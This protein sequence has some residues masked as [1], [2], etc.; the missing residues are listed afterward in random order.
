MSFHVVKGGVLTTI[1]DL[2]RTGF[3]DQGVLESGAMDR[4]S[5]RTA[6]LLVGNEESEACLE[7]TLN[8]PEI[9]INKDSLIAVTGEGMVPFIEGER[10]P[11]GTPIYV[12]AG[13]TLHF[14]STKTGCRTYLAVAGGLEV[15]VVMNSKST[16]L[17]A[18]LGGYK[19]RALQKGDCL[20]IGEESDLAKKKIGHFKQKNAANPQSESWSANGELLT[21][22]ESE[23]TIR[24]I[25]G[26]HFYRFTEESQE[27]F[28]SRPFIVSP[29]SDRMGYRLS[30]DSSLELTESFSLLSEAVAFGTIQVPPDGQPIVLMADR[31][32]TGG[33]PRIAQVVAVDLGR[34]AQCRPKDEILFKE[35]SLAEAEALFIKQEAAMSARKIGI[36]LKHR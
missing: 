26:T 8:G 19:G 28:F 27:Q 9:E 25:R 30:V 22:E 32:T 7:M 12:P 15:P 20:H 34:L 13:R 10:F 5:L 36:Y 16:Y 14:K 24:V 2:G 6:N 35:I 23:T 21:T 11:V 17:R 3:L 18:R 1:Q 4:I 33:Y 29:K 31:Q